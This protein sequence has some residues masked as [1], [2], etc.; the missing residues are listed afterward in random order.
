MCLTTLQFIGS[1][2]YNIQG[3]ATLTFCRIYGN[4]Y[5]N[6]GKVV[7][8]NNWWGSNNKPIIKGFGSVSVTP[9]L[10][11]NLTAYPT[12]IPKGGTSNIKADLSHDSNRNLVIG[13]SDGLIYFNTTLGTINS[14]VLTVN[15]VANAILGSGDVSGVA[16]VTA[17]DSP[18]NAVTIYTLVTIDTLP[19]TITFVDP[20]NNAVNVPSNKIIKITFN[21]PIQIG[22]GLIELTNSLGTIIPIT[23]SISGNILT[24]TP[25][26][27]LTV[28]QYTIFLHYDSVTDLAGNPIADYSSSFT[29]A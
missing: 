23:T 28:D 7:A 16:N 8:P 18:A 6:N 29:T 21:E 5:N 15:G 4:I 22:N 1:G 25:N 20:A 10:V 11:L 19:P 2:I 12:L 3:T 26:N 27:P 13:F 14:P 24:I 17:T 9:W